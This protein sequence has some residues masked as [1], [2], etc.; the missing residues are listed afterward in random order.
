MSEIENVK[1]GPDPQSLDAKVVPRDGASTVILGG[2]RAYARLKFAR[3]FH[4]TRHDPLIKENLFKLD[5]AIRRPFPAVGETLVAYLRSA[6]LRVTYDATAGEALALE[7]RRMQARYSRTLP[8]L[9]PDGTTAWEH[10]PGTIDPDDIA[11]AADALRYLG[12]DDT[13]QLFPFSFRDACEVLTKKDALI[14]MFTGG[15]KTREAFAIADGYNYLDGSDATT[16]IV[17]QKRHLRSWRE[18]LGGVRGKKPCGLLVARYGAKCYEEFTEKDDN[19]QFNQP[20]LLVSFERLTRASDEQLARL[21]V[22]AKGAVVILDEAY[23]IANMKAQRTQ[24]V[25]DVLQGRHHLALSAT[26]FKGFVNTLLPILQWVFRGGSSALPDYPTDR[27]GSARKFTAQF[28]SKAR[29]ESGSTKTIPF[30]RNIDELRDLLAPLMVRRLRGEPEVCA[31]LKDVQLEEHHIDVDLNEAHRD[32]YRAVLKT[33][34]DW[35]KREVAARRKAGKSAAIPQNEVLIKLGYLVRAVSQP[36]RMKDHSDEEFTFPA[37]PRAPTSLHEEAMKIARRHVE[38][39]D[40]VLIFGFMTDQLDMMAEVLRAEGLRVGVVHGGI[41]QE[42]RDEEI[43]LLQQGETQVL[44]GSYSTAAEG[45]NMDQANVVICTEWHWVPSVIKQAVGR[46][47]RGV[48]ELVPI[49]YYLTARGT[50]HEYMKKNCMLKTDASSAALDHTEQ[51]ATNEDI[52]DLNVFCSSLVD[53]EGEEQ[54]QGQEY[55]IE[56]EDDA[57]PTL[58]RV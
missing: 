34:T 7:M 55:A 21:S 46:I 6:G 28:A 22:A 44:L 57:M 20:Y 10:V 32:M 18:E 49:A 11:R 39:G 26:P 27:A 15:G 36:W 25:F 38:D 8:V 24:A 5:E 48:Q 31:V 2:K 50:V 16:I 51:I 42:R 58:L 12:W 47:M 56:L 54:V 1:V 53:I 4:G 41:S 40:A 3:K 52:L 19:P 14:T 13:Q 17:A 37:Y 30:I 45:L 43:S 33:F 29:S 35:Y 9:Q 23:T